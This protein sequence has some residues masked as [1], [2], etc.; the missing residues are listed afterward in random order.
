MNDGRPVPR[1][2]VDLGRIYANACVL[3]GRLAQRGMDITAVL[4]ATLGSPEVAKTVLA[5]G[6]RTLA[7]SRIENVETLRA[8]GITTP[9]TLIRTPML[10][11]V[12]RVVRHVDLSCNTEVDVIS[13]LSRAARRINRSHRVMLMVEL[14]DLREGILPEDLPEIVRMVRRMPNIIVA[15]IGANLACRSG[16][17]PDVVN[18]K[19]LS[20]LAKA[21]HVES[22]T[23]RHVLVSGGNSANIDWALGCADTG[24]INDL[25]LGEAL[26]LGRNPLDRMP[27]D[28]LH[29]DA[30]TLVAEVIESKRK[31][32]MPWGHRAQ[33]AAGDTPMIPDRGDVQQAILAIGRQDMDPDDLL[34][35]ADIRLHGASS[36]HL[37]VESASRRLAVGEEIRF[38]PG[39]N[40]LLRLMTSPHVGKVYSDGSQIRHPELPPASIPMSRYSHT[41]A[42]D[43]A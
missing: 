7:D 8:S 20:S 6:I 10:T 12:D 9:I 23:A 14:G 22:D 37:I 30:F 28:G 2:E 1:V 31:P 38:I 25:R 15:G 3:R 11:Q 17:V 32:T 40:A 33:N 29:V 34:A 13:A 27:V 43:A 21:M 35:P 26:L 41:I 42:A 4:K 16:V 5:A 19:V 18:M 24:L 39:Y 36:D